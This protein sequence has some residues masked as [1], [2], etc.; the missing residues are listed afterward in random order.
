MDEAEAR[1]WL[2]REF[3]VPRETM[4][5]L[6]AFVALL[7]D[8]NDAPEPRFRASLDHVWLRHIVDSAQL[9]PL[10]AVGRR[11]AGSISAPAPAFPA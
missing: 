4:E 7:R 10:R 11:R 9:L 1:A 3:D 8:E 2:E 5:R 6:E